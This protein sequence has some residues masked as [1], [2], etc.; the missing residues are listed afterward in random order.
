M[1]LEPH[2]RMRGLFVYLVC[3]F[4]D[5]MWFL[6][7]PTESQSLYQ[8]IESVPLHILA[9]HS[10]P[11]RCNGF[12]FSSFFPPFFGSA[13]LMNHSFL[14]LLHDIHE[15]ATSFMQ[16]VCWC[17]LRAHLDS[18]I[19]QVAFESCIRYSKQEYE[20]T[21]RGKSSGKR[22]KKEITVRLRRVHSMNRSTRNES[23]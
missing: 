13:S 14:N 11:S 10:L 23:T 8:S 22:K 5:F 2:D 20:S 4:H 21:V 12:I 7:R 1:N 9:R 18:S 3:A 6:F 16:V 15:Y 17:M 19:D